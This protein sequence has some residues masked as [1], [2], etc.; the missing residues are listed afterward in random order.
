VERRG[1]TAW[2]VNPIIKVFPDDA[3]GEAP[4]RIEI[5]AARNECEPFQ[6]ALRA[7]RDLQDVTIT[8]DPP[9]DRAGNALRDIAVNLV[10]FVPIDHPSSYYRV[11]VPAWYRKLPPRGRTGCDGWAGLWPDPLPPYKPFELEAHTTQPIWATIHVPT[12]AKPGTYRGRLAIKPANAPA[13]EIPLEVTVWDFTLP[14]ESHV[15]VIYDFREHF[16]RQFGGSGGTREQALRKW[17]RFLADHRISPGILPSPRFQY[18]NGQV[19]MDT[20]GFDRAASY[21]LD[22]L[23]MNVFYSPWFF[24]AFGWARA[25]R[26]LF[27]FEPFTKEYT[28]AYSKCLKAYMD[29]LRKK[30]WAEKVI[31]YISDEPHF[32]HDHIKKQMIKVCG[33]IRS[34]E[35]Q[36]RIYSSTWRY[37]REWAGHINV[38]G[39]GPHGS[40]PVE[41]MRQRQKAGDI[42]WFTTD[43]HMCLDTPYCA[44]E[45]LLP[46]LCWKYGVE[47][48]EFWGVNWFTYDP[49]ERGWHRFI[50]QSSDGKTYY[51]VRYPNGDGYLAYPGGRVGVDGPVSSIRLEQAREGIEDYEYLYLLDQLIAEAKKRGI[52]TRRAER[53]RAEAAELVS[54]PNRG[55]RYSTSLLPDPGAVPRLRAQVAR[56]IERL[57]RRLK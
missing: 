33:M 4:S 53:V 27:G 50:S 16:T 12:E 49:W 51:Y 40:F 34:V 38:W 3:P 32:R 57:G 15:R 25:P 11:D 1:Y 21:C 22:E 35:P 6:L 13:L 37:C 18:K 54:I 2:L 42:I 39:A 36:M 45:R 31:L 20:T 9:R 30:G 19:A 44:I 41:L 14:K 8:I 5:A 24:Y 10:G 55:G 29:H 7:I 52:A 17:Y 47:A 26:K 56:A 46:W 43:G 28:D 23:G 48:Y